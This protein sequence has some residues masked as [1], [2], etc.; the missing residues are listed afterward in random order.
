MLQKVLIFCY[1]GLFIFGLSIIKYFVLVS[2]VFAIRDCNTIVCS[3]TDSGFL[4]CNADK[5]ACLK[6]N[7]IEVQGQATTLNN[8][9]NIL[10]S[11]ISLQESQI[12]QTQA[13]IAQLERQINELGDR[14]SGL[15]ISLDHFTETLVQR[16]YEDYKATRVNSNLLVLTSD[17]LTEFLSNNKYLQ[18][19]R[20][21]TTTAMQEA[22]TQKTDYDQ[23]K[24]LKET[25]QNEVEKKRNIL[26]Q[27]QRELASQR[28]AQ[29]SLLDQTKNDEKRFQSLLAQAQAE[30][31]SLRNFS[32]SK[33]GSILPPQNSPDGW[34]FSQ[35]DERWANTCIGNSCGTIYQA[36]IMEVGCLI[37]S[38]AMVKKKYGED[39][40]PLTIGTNPT[41]FSL[42]TAY[43]RMPWPTP[44]GFH[45]VRY[46]TGF[47]LDKIDPALSDGRP[48]IVHLQMG[49]NDGHFVVLK[50]G[51]NG[52]YIMHDPIVGYDKNFTDFY[53]TSQ[54][55]DFSVLE[56]G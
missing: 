55:S 13:E 45:Y 4:T 39:V 38:T 46:Y 11:Q 7:I 21:Q 19:T 8:T 2:P 27:Q 44:N 23:Q 14:I 50:S 18:L 6:Q 10:N 29:Q 31:A 5:Q 16:V 49:N 53:R 9:I 40:S 42:N 52:S 15:N 1:C 43:M 48:V 36:T 33:G 47:N 26:Q 37:S 56:R 32:A 12:A 51:S 24:A 54:I 28:S 30:V 20:Q 22:E 25:K 35:R 34:Y 3:K 17:S 41:Y